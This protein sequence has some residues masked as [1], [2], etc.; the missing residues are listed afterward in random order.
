MNVRVI[1][2]GIGPLAQMITK[3]IVERPSISIVGAVDINPALANKDLGDVC[4]INP[5]GV[6]IQTDIDT[7]LAQTNA[8]AILL[9]TVSSAKAIQPQIETILKYKLPIV[10]TCEELIYPWDESPE[11]ASRLS[12]LAE[13]AGVAILGTGVNPGFLMDSLPTFLTSVCQH[14]Q[15]VKVSRIQDASFRRVPFQRKIGAG[16]DLEAFEQ[17]KATGSLRHVGL[18]ESIQLIA[19]ALGWKLTKTED[20]ITPVICEHPIETSALQIPAGYAT[21]VQQIGRGWINGDEKIT[22]CFRAAVGEREPQDTIEIQGRPNITSTIA[23]GV[24]GDVA[25]CAISLN[26]L[27]QIRKAKP[28]LRTMAEMPLVSYF[29]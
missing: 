8:D 24:N 6:A 18:T 19:N 15:S 26:A 27:K 25:T 23:G 22:L 3:F 28:G 13:S 16:L 2:I 11:V 21:G 5:L 9:T 4:G 20:I 10:T 17:K 29:S 1:Q 7:C 12:T 14:V